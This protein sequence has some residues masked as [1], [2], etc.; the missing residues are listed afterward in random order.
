RCYQW[1]A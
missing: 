1:L